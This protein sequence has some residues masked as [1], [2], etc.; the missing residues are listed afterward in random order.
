MLAAEGVVRHTR[1]SGGTLD[2]AG[3]NAMGQ[4]Y[5]AQHVQ[6]TISGTLGP[7]AKL[8]Q[9]FGSYTPGPFVRA[10]QWVQIQNRDQFQPAQT[11]PSGTMMLPIVQTQCDAAGMVTATLGAFPFS[12]YGNLARLNQAVTAV[13]AGLNPVT[14]AKA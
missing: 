8:K 11:A 5:L 3:A 2:A 10:G 12:I 14:G 6:P 1:L 13:K 9:P 7:Y 4:T